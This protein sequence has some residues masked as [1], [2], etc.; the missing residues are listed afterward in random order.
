MKLLVLDDQQ[1]QYL[2]HV[3]QSYCGAGLPLTELAIAAA[4]YHSVANARDVLI[5]E[6]LGHAKAEIGQRAGA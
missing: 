2:L 4:T 3:F 1:Q 5:E 6:H